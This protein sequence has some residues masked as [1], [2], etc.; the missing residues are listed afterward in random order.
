MTRCALDMATKEARRPPRGAW[1]RGFLYLRFCSP[2]RPAVATRFRTR[3]RAAIGLYHVY[4]L[5]RAGIG[6]ALTV[7]STAH[8]GERVLEAFLP[9]RVPVVLIVCR[10]SLTLALGRSSGTVVS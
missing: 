1:R 6:V 4:F 5:V 3:R 8:V 2:S 9:P 7:R 10:H